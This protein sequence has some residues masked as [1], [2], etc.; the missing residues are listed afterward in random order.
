MGISG[1]LQSYL[2]SYVITGDPNTNRVKWYQNLP[3]SIEWN[4]PSSNSEKIGGVVK[5]GNWHFSTFD[6]DQL[7]KSKC[8]FWRQFASAATELGGYAPPDSASIAQKLVQI[9]GN[10]STSIN[11]VG[12]NILP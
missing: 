1:A 5:V 8:D 2:T 9:P 10:M 11:Y 6:D 3:P 12:G 4:R 7:P